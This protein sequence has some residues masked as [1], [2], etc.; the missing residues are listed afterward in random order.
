MKPLWRRVC[1]LLGGGK[2]DPPTPQRF[3]IPPEFEDLW[4]RIEKFPI[5]KPGTDFPLSKRLSKEQ[6]WNLEFTLRVIQEYRKFLF[7]CVVSPHMVTPSLTVDEA[8][9]MHLIYSWNYWVDL[10]VGTLRRLIHHQPSEGG[11]TEDDKFAD[12][13]QRTLALYASYFGE[14]P[15]DI[16]GHRDD[17]ATTPTGRVAM[18]GEE[19]TQDDLLG[20]MRGSQNKAF[21]AMLMTAAGTKN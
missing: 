11:G 9:H 14:P 13:Y 8:W 19:V 3:T 15:V 4:Q 16:W 5:D 17:A 2:A 21:M 12:L 6:D 20:E 18:R 1:G 10:C 7:L